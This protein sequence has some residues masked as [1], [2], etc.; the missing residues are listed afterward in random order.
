MSGSSLEPNPKIFLSSVTD[1]FGESRRLVAARIKQRYTVREQDSF[2]HEQDADTLLRQIHD[3][4]RGCDA[5]VAIVGAGSGSH[6]KPAEAADFGYM[7]PD[8]FDELSYTQWELVFALHYG[9]STHLFGL[10]TIFDGNPS[11]LWTDKRQ[12]RFVRYVKRTGFPRTPF[13]RA[14]DLPD[15]VLKSLGQDDGLEPRSMLPA[16][17]E[18]HLA[19]LERFA[20][21]RLSDMGGTRIGSIREARRFF[22][23]RIASDA[24]NPDQHVHLPA[25]VLRAAEIARRPGRPFDELLIV[26]GAGEGKSTL[27]Y[28]LLCNLTH[29]DQVRR[30]RLVPMLADCVTLYRLFDEDTSK[31][32]EALTRWLALAVAPRRFEQERPEDHPGRSELRTKE[33]IAALNGGDF[34]LL[35]MIDGFDELDPSA[36]LD[37]NRVSRLLTALHTWEHR[38][39]IRECYRIATTRPYFENVEGLT[40]M[41]RVDLLPPSSHQVR[42]LALTHGVS[43]KSLKRFCD[44]FQNPDEI[45]SKFVY[46][47]PLV[48]YFASYPQSADGRI[49]RLKLMEFEVDQAVEQVVLQLRSHQQVLALSEAEQLKWNQRNLLVLIA[50]RLLDQQDPD[51]PGHLSWKTI[52]TLAK[53]QD[54]SARVGQLVEADRV[55]S[56]ILNVLIYA[57]TGGNTAEAGEDRFYRLPHNEYRDY[58]LA[59]GIFR[60]VL[61]QHPPKGSDGSAT[62]ADLARGYRRAERV[63]VF[64]LDMIHHAAAESRM[65]LT[66]AE[67][68]RRVIDLMNHRLPNLEPQ[69]RSDCSPHG[70]MLT[71]LLDAGPMP[72]VPVLK[73]AGVNFHGTVAR[74][75]GTARLRLSTNRDWTGAVLREAD[76]RGANLSNLDLSTANLDNAQLNGADLSHANLVGANLRNAAMGRYRDWPTVL[77]G[78]KFDDGTAGSLAADWFNYRFQGLKGYCCFYDLEL[79]KS[80]RCVIV[81]ASHGLLVLFDLA[82]S[83]WGPVYLKTEHTDDILDISKHPSGDL[84]VT[85]SRDH[86]VGLYRLPSGLR[87]DL[88]PRTDL[89]GMAVHPI[90]PLAVL[91]DLFPE[92]SYPRRAQFSPSGRWLA[93]IARDP[94]VAFIPIAGEI[95]TVEAFGASVYGRAHAGPVMCIESDVEP[96]LNLPAG[97]LPPD[98]F[99]TAGYDGRMV[100]WTARDHPDP[101]QVWTPSLIAKEPA[102][103]AEIDRD[104]IRALVADTSE[105]TGGADGFWIGTEKECKLRYYRRESGAYSEEFATPFESGVFSL[106]RH[107]SR[108]LLAVGLAS[109]EALVFQAD[110]SAPFDFERPRWRCRT[111]DDIVR[112]MQFV[113]HGRRLLVATWDGCFGLFDLDETS[114]ATDLEPSKRFLYPEEQWRPQLDVSNLEIDKSIDLGRSRGISTRMKRYLHRVGETFAKS[115]GHER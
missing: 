51:R 87:S 74:A 103:G 73:T 48:R 105:D 61:D 9:K 114:G 112:A 29:R 16:P 11:V 7:L 19:E 83:D 89:D 18:T 5:V 65:G 113:D 8:G 96:F 115:A 92:P 53:L 90:R 31:D 42:Q 79:A 94:R 102:A 98:R 25:D 81:G 46:F 45:D 57:G 21:R 93:V 26:A 101:E 97:K 34:R 84:I 80:D 68:S 95:A 49:S 54:P 99:Y 56:K 88:P 44:T 75:S 107:T 63:R 43:R 86:T 47:H 66:V 110:D 60:L 71:L 14:G 22:A 35:L 12:K 82:S 27:L 38:H 2:R 100:M 24:K 106:V 62:A 108:N 111:S 77:T 32:L 91:R 50:L 10:S 59:D 104:I 37:G 55:S 39:G 58:L 85:S 13:A 20:L 33:F 41:R 17:I 1:E 64:L 36:T 76:L 28:S 52:A 67:F 78:A 72:A 4:I 6:P 15:L 109:G 69:E 23:P 40:G 3:Y 70:A 30:C